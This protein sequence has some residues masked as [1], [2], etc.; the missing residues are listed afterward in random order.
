M[1][2]LGSILVSDPS[3]CVISGTTA[4]NQLGTDPRLG[5]L[6]DNG[7]P[8]LTHALLPGS[9]AI[10]AVTA[11]NCPA[12]DQRGV[13]RPQDGTGDGVRAC[14]IGAFEVAP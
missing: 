7:G 2:S 8:T 5:P 10:D 9:P 4:G 14:D 13:S 1:N 12:A 6:A 3:G 11:G